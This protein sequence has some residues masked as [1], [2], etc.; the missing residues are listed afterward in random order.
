MLSPRTIIFDCDGVILDSNPLKTKAFEKVAEPY[1][2]KAAEALVRYHVEYGGISRYR[3]FEYFVT[4]ILGQEAN[5]ELV[6]RLSLQFGEYVFNALLE[7]PLTPGLK[8][9]RDATPGVTW[10]IVSGGDEKELNRVF[11]Q[12]GIAPY[13]DG[14]IYGSPANKHEILSRL[15]ANAVAQ[16]PALFV[17]DSRYDHEAAAKAGCS[18]VFASA[19]TEFHE[20][21]SYCRQND[22]LVIENLQDIVKLL[23]LKPDRERRQS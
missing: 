18:F 16:H 9:L 17:G 1:G 10:I 5:P 12:R 2:Q 3:K 7:C 23:G 8:Q 13:F 6:N 19:W 11:T 14:G 4:E 20:W 22:L 15:F 21:E